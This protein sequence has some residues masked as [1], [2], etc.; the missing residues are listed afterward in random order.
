MRERKGQEE[1]VG[2]VVIMLL[3]AVAF[4]IFLGLYLRKSNVDLRVES[5]EVSQF[6]DAMVEYTTECS[7]NDGYS[8]ESVDELASECD[9]GSICSNGRNACE[10]LKETSKEV[11]E[12]SWN[13]GAQAPLKGYRFVIDFNSTSV[14]DISLVQN[15]D[16]SGAYRG[17]IRP[18]QKFKFDLKL[19]LN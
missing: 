16:T 6:L 17:G 2:F 13:F 8:F 15:C 18:F 5:S 7:V 1:M 3:V 11:I 19:C 10:V 9:D 14:Q 12:S 4:L